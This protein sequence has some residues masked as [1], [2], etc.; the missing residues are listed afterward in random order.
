MC[1]LRIGITSEPNGII[2]IPSPRCAS[3]WPAG[4]HSN[5]LAAHFVE[6]YVYNVVVPMH[7]QQTSTTITQRTLGY[8]GLCHGTGSYCSDM[9]RPVKPTA[10]SQ[11]RQFEF[12][13]GFP[14]Q[15]G[16]PALWFWTAGPMAAK[17][18]WR[19]LIT[20]ICAGRNR[21]VMIRRELPRTRSAGGAEAVPHR[22]E[23]GSPF[24]GPLT[25]T[26][27]AVQTSIVVQAACARL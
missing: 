27:F 11:L 8:P 25:A 15:R 10:P 23:E 19:R 6:F 9:E 18:L 26:G 4:C 2:Q 22:T 14:L 12:R 5:S 21:R 24:R 16:K 20:L 7:T 17:K 1:G 3:G 13:A